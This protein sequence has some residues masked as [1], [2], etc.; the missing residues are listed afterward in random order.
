L[1]ATFVP[2]VLVIDTTLRGDLSELLLGGDLSHAGK[3]AV[4][5]ITAHRST[6]KLFFDAS[7]ASASS[8]GKTSGSQSALASVV[9]RLFVGGSGDGNAALDLEDNVVRCCDFNPSMPDNLYL[10][11]GGSGPQTAYPSKK[12]GE[13]A[14][15]LRAAL[16]ESESKWKVM[17]DTDG[18]QGFSDYTK[19]AHALCDNCIIPLKTNVNDFS[20]RCVPMLE[21]LWELK[22]RG[23]ARSRVQL[24]VWNEVDVQ[25]NAPSPVSGLITPSKAAQGV[26]A[27]LN[28]LVAD[29][30]SNY[31]D[32]F[33]NAA[34]EDREQIVDFCKASTMCMRDF[35][36]TGM[37]AAEHG[38]PFVSMKAGKLEGGRLV[39][40]IGGDVLSSAQ[41]NVAELADVLDD[42]AWGRS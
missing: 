32:L 6:T 10:C 21:E 31:P 19:I 26:I 9:G 30:A 7:S 20:N 11:P 17:C 3:K 23:Q 39:Y 24:I 36:V 5:A 34:P 4:Q 13:V 2:Q 18:D 28:G 38:M 25:K 8:Q 27:M 15:A 41:I 1:S 40:D 12:R 33:F 14:E 37:A 35:G 42:P 22:E 16:V 29:V